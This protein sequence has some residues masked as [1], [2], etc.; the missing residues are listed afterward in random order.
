MIAAVYGEGAVASGTSVGA[1]VI[2]R[3]RSEARCRVRMVRRGSM[4]MVRLPAFVVQ[5]WRGSVP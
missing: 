4:G 2:V 5:G 3:G 1:V